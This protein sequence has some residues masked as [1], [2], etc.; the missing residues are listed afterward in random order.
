M[1]CKGLVAETFWSDVQESVRNQTRTLDS[2]DQE[3]RDQRVLSEVGRSLSGR[4][5]LGAP[6]RKEDTQVP[7]RSVLEQSSV[8][9]VAN[10]V[11]GEYWPLSPTAA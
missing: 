2:A 9:D 4:K 8:E 7:N 10:L 6:H 11:G 5:H 1:V 3:K